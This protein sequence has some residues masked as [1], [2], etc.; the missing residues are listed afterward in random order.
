MAEPLDEPLGVVASDELADDRARFSSAAHRL[1][2][3]AT[4]QPTRSS[5]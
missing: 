4:C 3:F 1:P 2:S 5:H